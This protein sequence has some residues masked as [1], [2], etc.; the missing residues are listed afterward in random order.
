MTLPNSDQST[1]EQGPRLLIAVRK[2]VAYNT[3][4][5]VFRL[6]QVLITTLVI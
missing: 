3:L 2:S 1:E 6:L 4:L 5:L